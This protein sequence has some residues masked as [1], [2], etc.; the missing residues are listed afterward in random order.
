M[1]P[2]QRECLKMARVNLLDTV[3]MQN[4]MPAVLAVQ[5]KIAELVEEIEKMLGY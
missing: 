4:G 2:A 5:E 1:T 3:N